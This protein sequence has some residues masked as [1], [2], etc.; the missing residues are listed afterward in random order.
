MGETV[1]KGILVSIFVHTLLI[2]SYA[3]YKPVPPQRVGFRVEE[4][5]GSTVVLRPIYPAKLGGEVMQGLLPKKGELL[6]CNV[7][8]EM[9]EM[10]DKAGNVNQVHRMVLYCLSGQKIVVIGV[11]Y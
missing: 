4:A 1:R 9:T 5:K 6:T 8:D 2:A 7:T 10:K 11:E 3:F